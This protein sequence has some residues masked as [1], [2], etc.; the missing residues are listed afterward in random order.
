MKA[1]RQF[2]TGGSSSVKSFCRT[3][4]SLSLT[5]N[6]IPT[7]IDNNDKLKFVGLFNKEHN[8][9]SLPQ[10]THRSSFLFPPA[11]RLQRN[12]GQIAARS[13]G[14]SRISRDRAQAG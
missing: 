13:R 14:E 5:R 8:C 7:I 6:G 2:S 4:F 9:V 3:N 12:I 10:T 11:R 1:K